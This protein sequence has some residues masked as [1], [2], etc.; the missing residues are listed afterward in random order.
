MYVMNTPSQI[1]A[2]ELAEREP[3]ASTLYASMLS[4]CY[5]FGTAAGSFLGGAVQGSWG[6]ELPGLPAPVFALLALIMNRRLL[7]AAAWAAA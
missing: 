5:N 4:V 2:I 6:L 3:P 1:H 7:C